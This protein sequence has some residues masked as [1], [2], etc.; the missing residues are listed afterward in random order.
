MKNCRFWFFHQSPGSPK[1][2]KK[3]YEFWLMSQLEL[4]FLANYWFNFVYWN[5]SRKL[6]THSGGIGW[7]YFTSN[8]ASHQNPDIPRFAKVSMNSDN[9]IFNLN[10]LLNY[11]PI[12]FH[13][14]LKW[15]LQTCNGGFDWKVVY[16]DTCIR[17]LIVQ[18]FR[19]VL[20]ISTHFDIGAH[21]CTW[22]H[23]WFLFSRLKLKAVHL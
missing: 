9:S 11:R 14:A 3:C 20:G 21:V 16:F 12:F 19:K 7:K 13:W 22:L 6:H 4:T 17:I 23:F 8:L 10:F 2:P 15:T 18:K 5:R 1:N